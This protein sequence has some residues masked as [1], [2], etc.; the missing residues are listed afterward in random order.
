MSLIQSEHFYTNFERN[1]VVVLAT[2]GMMSLTA[3]LMALVW[4]VP[5]TERHQRTQIL[6]Y[7]SCLLVS[8]V[9]QSIGTVMSIK[10][11]NLGGV[12][13]G[14]FCSA[15]GGIKQAGNIGNALW[16]FLISVHLFNMLFL[17]YAVT[18]V[19]FVVTLVAGWACVILIVIIGPTVIENAA[20]GPYFGISGDWCWITDE[21]PK[22]QTFLEYFFEYF[23]A[24]T[25]IV[26]YSIILLRVRGNLIIENGRPHLRFVSKEDYWQ[27]SLRRDFTDLSVVRAV[28]QMIW[29]PVAYSILIVPIG[30]ARLSEFAGMHVPQWA[31][32]VTDVI[33]NLTGL[34]NVVVLLVT[35][36]LYPEIHSLPQFVTPRKQLSKSIHARHGIEPFMLAFNG[37]E[38]LVPPVSVPVVVRVPVRESKPLPPT[39][40]V[41]R[42]SSISSVSTYDSQTPL[43]PSDV[44]TLI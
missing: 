9:V 11:V 13:A 4:M 40:V 21:Y 12:F 38:S 26:L 34:V 18:K 35:H 16:S 36:R 1:G 2:A 44:H 10:W 24:G 19:G 28:Q 14:S 6:G 31:T 43:H 39:P 3:V 25:S 33:F 37:S 22:E 42:P 8:N 5:R 32:I 15:Q 27:L 7:F 20:I 30:L 23:S 17:R 29:Y 41:V